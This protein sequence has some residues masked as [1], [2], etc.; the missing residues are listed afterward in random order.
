MYGSKSTTFNSNDVSTLSDEEQLVNDIEHFEKTMF[1]CKSDVQLVAHSIAL[2]L[3]KTYEERLF[4]S[5]KYK[6]WM[7]LDETCKWKQ[8]P[9]NPLTKLCRCNLTQQYMH[10]IK[11]YTYEITYHTDD[12]DQLTIND[13]T[14]KINQCCAILV[15]LTNQNSELMKRIITMSFDIFVND[16]LMS[17]FNNLQSHLCFDDV[18]YDYSSEQ[19]R[20]VQYT[21]N[22]YSYSHLPYPFIPCVSNKQEN[23]VSENMVM[24]CKQLMYPTMNSAQNV[25]LLKIDVVE[26]EKLGSN[27]AKINDM[28]YDVLGKMFGSYVDRMSCALIRKFNYDFT[29]HVITRLTLFTYDKIDT[30][31]NPDLLGRLIDTTKTIPLIIC[32]QNIEWLYHSENSLSFKPIE[33]DMSVLMSAYIQS[34]KS[35]YEKMYGQT[36]QQIQNVMSDIVRQSLT[37]H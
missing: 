25:Y 33:F 18:V 21:K 27:T 1:M 10:L 19:Q 8:Y 16:E 31:Y 7:F 15:E 12:L 14:N 22:I 34:D 35:D 30:H 2:L 23:E 11:H 28:I 5:S 37:N 4:Y 24:L 6:I 32:T 9:V 13:Y 26:L 29:E 36:Q 3:H 17:K 20:L